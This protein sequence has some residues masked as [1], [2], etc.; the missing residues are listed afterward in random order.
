MIIRCLSGGENAFYKQE[1]YT[2]PIDK[3]G[4]EKY[5]YED[6]LYE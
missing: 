3:T 6:Y 5:R 2:L 1:D 4:D